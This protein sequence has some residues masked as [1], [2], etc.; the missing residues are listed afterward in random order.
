MGLLAVTE[1][2]FFSPGI[3]RETRLLDIHIDND[4]M[5]TSMSITTD[6]ADLHVNF[7]RTIRKEKNLL[8]SYTMITMKLIKYPSECNDTAHPPVKNR[9]WEDSSSWG[10]WLF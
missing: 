9:S 8:L 4:R 3:V 6:N 10:G 5:M 1:G 2:Y 7:F